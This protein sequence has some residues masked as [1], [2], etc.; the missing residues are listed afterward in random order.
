M[1]ISTE[2]NG[3][4][5]RFDSG[6]PLDISIPLIF[7]GPQPNAFEVPTATSQ[8]CETEN[9]IGDTR[10]GGSCNFEEY[11]LIPHCNGTHT[12]SIGH[13]TDERIS[14]L[15][16]LK[17]VFIPTTLVTVEPVPSNKTKDSYVPGVASDDSIITKECMQD[18]L[19]EGNRDWLD[20]L[21]IRTLPNDEGK[22]S[23]RY[24]EELPAF[25]SNDAM[26]FVVEMGVRHLLVD[27]PSIDKTFD[28]GK[29]S[30]HRIFWNIPTESRE[31]TAQSRR[32]CTITEMVYVPDSIRD[33]TYLL[34]LQIA[35][36]AADASPSRPILFETV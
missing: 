28:E 33:G 14:V 16:S 1:L 27:L 26:E 22:I 5:Y 25:L 4:E 15:D 13:I 2:I 30:N 18:A 36:F 3:K 17:D 31:A 8:P 6:S 34:N 24:M 19:G 7:N 23:R 9:F 21:V 12:E 29:L 32:N 20:G 11:R 10:R 35:P